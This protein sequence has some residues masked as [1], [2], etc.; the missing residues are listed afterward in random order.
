M[1]DNQFR[2]GRVE[3]GPE[4]LTPAEERRIG[5]ALE[6]GKEG[7]HILGAEFCICAAM[8]MDDGV[9]IR[10]HRHDSCLVTAGRMGYKR[11]QLRND[12]QGFVTS[13]NRFVDRKEG[14]RLQNAARIN[15]VQTKKPVVDLLFSED[16]Y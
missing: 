7:V 12:Q 1:S 15:S 2:V 14:A 9:I 13:Q 3:F 5:R 4:R 6:L 16:L 8:L 10:G 11:N